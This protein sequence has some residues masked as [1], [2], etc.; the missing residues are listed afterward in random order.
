MELDKL[1][2]S[3]SN[4]SPNEIS[5]KT[6]LSI[7]EKLEI[8]STIQIPDSSFELNSS[9]T[10]GRTSETSSQS[11]LY[12]PLTSSCEQMDDDT[13]GSNTTL[14][15]RHQDSIDFEERRNLEL[16]QRALENDFSNSTLGNKILLNETFPNGAMVR[17]NSTLFESRRKSADERNDFKSIEQQI[18]ADQLSDNESFQLQDDDKPPSALSSN[19]LS[20]QLF[21]QLSQETHLIEEPEIA[22]DQSSEVFK[23][24]TP[25]I[26]NEYNLNEMAGSQSPEVSR[27]QSPEI[28]AKQT[29][30]IETDQ[31]LDEILG[32]RSP[33]IARIQ[34]P[35]TSTEQTLG[36]ETDQS[37]DE[38]PGNQS[39]DTETSCSLDEITESQ[40]SEVS[41]SQLL[42]ISRIRSPDL[43]I[44]HSLEISADQSQDTLLQNS[45][46]ISNDELSPQ[47]S[48]QSTPD[49]SLEVRET[50]DVE[51]MLE[52]RQV[53][54]EHLDELHSMP[55]ELDLEL[56]YNEHDSSQQS[57]WSTSP[58]SLMTPD[59]E[60]EEAFSSIEEKQEIHSPFSSEVHS[61]RSSV[62]PIHIRSSSFERSIVTPDE[63]S[64]SISSSGLSDCEPEW[65]CVHKD[66]EIDL[67]VLEEMDSDGLIE[68]EVNRNTESPSAYQLSLLK[69]QQEEEEQEVT[70]ARPP[71]PRSR[72]LVD[73]D[74][75]YNERK[76]DLQ[77]EIG[78]ESFLQEIEENREE[79]FID[80]EEEPSDLDEKTKRLEGESHELDVKS[81][82][83][84]ENE[85]NIDEDFND[86]EE[87]SNN[88]QGEYYDQKEESSE[89]LEE[90]QGEEED[91]R[92]PIADLDTQAET[93]VVDVETISR[94]EDDTVVSDLT[95]FNFYQA[96]TVSNVE[97]DN[98]IVI[99]T[100]DDRETIS[101]G[102]STPSELSEC[103]QLDA[104]L[105]EELTSGID[106]IICNPEVDMDPEIAMSDNDNID[107]FSNVT[108]STVVKENVTVT[109]TQEVRVVTPDQRAEIMEARA[110]QQENPTND[111]SDYVVSNYVTVDEN[112]T[113]SSETTVV[114]ETS[115]VN[116]IRTQEMS[117]DVR[118]LEIEMDPEQENLSGEDVIKQMFGN[119]KNVLE[120]FDGEE[121]DDGED[122]LNNV[123]KVDEYGTQV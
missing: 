107:L 121:D 71:S 111:V 67:T 117:E 17:E 74:S 1:A 21:R 103:E 87:Q 19:T 97:D 120:F 118:E 3:V 65:P 51:S 78:V 62:S 113:V 83:L 105:E 35:E 47:L 7:P 84:D 66:P 58:N 64:M 24:S 110:R 53:S 81:V 38:A 96:G 70:F 18:T 90:I 57:T 73:E 44:D 100:E 26:D 30:E 23:S 31:L 41:E 46:V 94:G 12:S 68:E 80:Q 39:P 2:V 48:R 9:L 82:N 88:Q 69:Q 32:N 98:T 101:S 28:P 22:E 16:A 115:K 119:H 4:A 59:N 20:Q 116:V 60:R 108:E 13:G 93:L 55:S 6:S 79:K 8:A 72:T 92:K 112:D 89:L 11:G 49:V 36:I 106:V 34:S 54:S 63:V 29:P 75:I 122:D 50:Q 99:N 104:P 33:E 95:E 27:I 102:H 109:T 76:E 114:S 52:E 91:E 10:S 15:G 25:E 37:P 86:Q 61:D 45:Q 5:P 77:T 85:N 56:N 123:G 40:S 14:S 43:P 42:D